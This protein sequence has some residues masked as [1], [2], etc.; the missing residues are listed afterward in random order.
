MLVIVARLLHFRDIV[1]NPEFVGTEMTLYCHVGGD[2]G[3]NH[4]SLRHQL[5]EIVDGT[6]SIF[7]HRT[8]QSL[9]GSLGGNH[10]YVSFREGVGRKMRE[11]FYQPCDRDI[12][13]V[14][15]I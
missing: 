10:L 9:I 6:V 3:V 11:N 8:V 4:A 15:H 14:L 12:E 13:D 1:G 7:D 5:C 2:T